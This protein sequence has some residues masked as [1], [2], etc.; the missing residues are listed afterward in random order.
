MVANNLKAYVEASSRREKSEMIN[1]LAQQIRTGCH[2]GG[3]VQKVSHAFRDCLLKQSRRKSPTLKKE[4]RDSWKSA[5]NEILSGL[6]PFEPP[7]D[8]EEDVNSSSEVEAAVT[9]LSLQAHPELSANLCQSMDPL[10]LDAHLDDGPHDMPYTE[11]DPVN[12]LSGDLA[13]GSIYPTGW[14]S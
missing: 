14:R 4:R 8:D 9:N 12:Q 13:H 5:Q 1:E 6:I 11:G 7:S 3:F 2:D 10:P